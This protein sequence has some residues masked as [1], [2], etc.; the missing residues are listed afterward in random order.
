MKTLLLVVILTCLCSCDRERS[1]GSGGVSARIKVASID[2]AVVMQGVDDWLLENGYQKKNVS[3]NQL[4]G[5]GQVQNDD[6]EVMSP[7]A[8]V[9]RLPNNQGHFAWGIASSTDSHQHV[10]I[11][12]DA[13][14]RATGDRALLA[15]EQSFEDE[16]KR[17]REY[18]DATFSTPPE[19]Q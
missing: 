15:L 14:Y 13:E 2:E 12:H 10:T 6:G 8:Y 19:A 16:S 5:D 18:I 3:W 9:K 4:T 7:V 11:F 1:A 17:F